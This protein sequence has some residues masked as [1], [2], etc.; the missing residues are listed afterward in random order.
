MAGRPAKPLGTGR[1]DENDDVTQI[2]PAGLEEDSGIE[3]DG[4]G[5]RIASARSIA[6]TNLARIKG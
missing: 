6:S 1:I 2:L 3:D 4:A 5:G